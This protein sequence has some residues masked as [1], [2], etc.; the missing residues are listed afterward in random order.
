MIFEANTSIVE[1]S[2]ETPSRPPSPSAAKCATAAR[3]KPPYGNTLPAVSAHPTG[4]DDAS[5]TLRD[6]S[7]DSAP[8]LSAQVAAPAVAAFKNVLRRVFMALPPFMGLRARFKITFR[9]RRSTSPEPEK[10]W[11]NSKVDL[12]FGLRR[13]GAVSFVAPPPRYS[14]PYRV[15]LASR[16]RYRPTF[17][18]ASEFHSEMRS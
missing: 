4:A 10:A 12:P 6:S 17:P 9:P 3:S 1:S 5:T 14:V 13:R 11:E 18:A 16:I 15:G 8:P 2:K 7:A